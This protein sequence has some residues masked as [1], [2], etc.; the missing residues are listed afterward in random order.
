MSI[1]H[2]VFSWGKNIEE[3]FKN[4]EIIEY[5]AEL[6]YITKNI[7]PMAETIEKYISNKHFQR[8][9]GPDKYYGQ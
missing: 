5:I 2:G 3:A 8:K 6:A 7:N 9:H 1:R 4:A